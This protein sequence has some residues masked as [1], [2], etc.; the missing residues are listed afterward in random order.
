[1]ANS[2]TFKPGD[3]VMLRSG[4]PTMTVTWVNDT[5]VGVVYW[6][7]RSNAIEVNSFVAAAVE[8]SS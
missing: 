4:S 1:M 5:D 7:D 8:S 6:N 3:L 2:Q